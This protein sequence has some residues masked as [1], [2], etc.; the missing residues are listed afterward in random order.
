MELR[1]NVIDLLAY[2]YALHLRTA[3]PEIQYEGF[4]QRRTL[5]PE[6]FARNR[7]IK[8]GSNNDPDG[9]S[10]AR[11]RPRSATDDLAAEKGFTPITERTC[12]SPRRLP[13]LLSEKV[14]ERGFRPDQL[15]LVLR[16]V[17]AR[18]R[19]EMVAEIRL[20]LLALLFRGRLLA[21]L[22]V[23]H[24]VLHAHL[25]HMQFRIAGLA[26]IQAP[27]GKAQ[28]RQGCAT[29]P[30]NQ[31]V[32]HGVGPIKSGKIRQLHNFRLNPTVTTL[33]TLAKKAKSMTEKLHFPVRLN[34]FFTCSY[35]GRSAGNICVCRELRR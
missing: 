4:P 11:G 18:L 1:K 23:A 32:G 34:Q 6:R 25:A 26:D 19:F 33:G 8:A 2:L 14:I 22:R 3:Y 9:A 28:C 31:G 30:T 20:V 10:H 15:P 27:Q 29:A 12:R 13:T 5:Q 24:V 17:S 21:M 7:R 35:S 16:Y